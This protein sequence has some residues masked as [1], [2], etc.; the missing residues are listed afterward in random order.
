M[1]ACLH[2]SELISGNV[3]ILP[4]YKWQVRFNAKAEEGN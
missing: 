1:G 2:W 3:M 4:P